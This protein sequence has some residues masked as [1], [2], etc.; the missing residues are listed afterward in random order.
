M[1]IN[2]KLQD[3][4]MEIDAG[5]NLETFKMGS[6]AEEAIEVNDFQNVSTFHVSR[7]F[8]RQA[9]AFLVWGEAVSPVFFTATLMPPTHLHCGVCAPWERALLCLPCP[10][11]EETWENIQNNKTSSGAVAPAVREDDTGGPLE[12][13]SSKLPGNMRFLSPGKEKR[14][15]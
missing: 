10:P 13:R 9:L 5:N 7:E 4:S 15:L 8:H 12:S 6:G 14:F 11:K 1:S 3:G 2:G